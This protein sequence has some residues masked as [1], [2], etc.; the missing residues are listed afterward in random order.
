[1]LRLIYV[2]AALLVVHGFA[3]AQITPEQQAEMTLNS[4]RKAYNE[5]NFA[6]AQ[7]KFREFLAKFGNHKDAP[8]ARYGLALAII[9]GPEKKYDE[10]RDIMQSLAATKDFADRALATYYAGVANRGLGLQSLNLAETMPNDAAKHRAN[11]Q[12]RFHEATPQFT[13]AMTSSP[14]KVEEPLVKDKL[15]FEAE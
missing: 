10:A 6:F 13:E 9:D 4:A 14:A 3:L 1:M 2:L 12:A 11:A 8:A 7:G 15:S 5:K